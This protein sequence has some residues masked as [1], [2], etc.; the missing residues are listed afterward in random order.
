M[1]NASGSH[2]VV[3]VWKHGPAPLPDFTS[4]PHIFQQSPIVAE[5]I[6]VRWAYFLAWQV[7]QRRQE[8]N[9]NTS[10]IS[11]C[12][13]TEV[14]V[15]VP[16]THPENSCQIWLKIIYTLD[17]CPLNITISNTD[18]PR[19]NTYRSNKTLAS[20]HSTRFKPDVATQEFILAL[21]SCLP[22]QLSSFL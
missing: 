12:H 3:P 22:Q 1:A 21:F 5:T 8:I 4:S 10:A 18:R 2:M 16:I 7:T 15:A 13:K 17:K 14:S 20:P 6:T 19:N 11:Y 9:E